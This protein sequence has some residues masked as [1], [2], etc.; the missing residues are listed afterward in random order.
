M[1]AR[2]DWVQADVRC[3]LCG[4]VLGRLVGPLPAGRT[5]IG[6]VGRDVPFAAFCSYERGVPARRLASPR[7]LRCSTCG[8]GVLVDDVEIF[9][10]Y[11]DP[12]PEPRLGRPRRGRPPKPW[13]QAPDRRLAELGL[14]G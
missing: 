2:R 3:L 10:T 7:Q 8:G 12:A 5:R 9:S 13:R 1:T 6:T 14:A 11:D 4:R